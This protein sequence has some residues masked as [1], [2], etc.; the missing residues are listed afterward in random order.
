MRK[1]ACPQ[2]H[3]IELESNE[4]KD[5]IFCKLCKKLFM[6]Y[7]LYIFQYSKSRQRYYLA[8][9]GMQP[10]KS[11][12][13]KGRYLKRKEDYYK[14]WYQENKLAVRSKQAEYR[15]KKKMEVTA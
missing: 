13:D 10:V 4:G 11:R 3:V 15:I 5:E 6:K 9:N 2:V 12:D 14:Q 1:Y 7:D 8:A